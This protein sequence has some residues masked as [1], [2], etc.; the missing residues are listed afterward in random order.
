VRR[1]RGRLLGRL[2]AMSARD[3]LVVG[4]PVVLVIAVAGWLAFKLVRPAPPNII[5][6]I[7][8][9]EGSS[10]RSNA[11]KYKKIIEKHGVKVEILT[12]KGSLD[13]LKLLAD[14]KYHGDVA[15]VQG[16][17]IEGVDVTGLMSLGT[18][19]AQP[20]MVYHREPQPVEVLSQLQ[21]K[22]LAIG[23]E[24]S[25]T[26]VLA[27]KLLKAN[28]IEGPPTVFVD[29]GGEEAA[30]AL[31]TGA[32]D[33]AFL[34]GDSATPK[35]MRGL[36][37]TPGVEM[38][39]FRQ[40]EGYLRKFRF[41]TRL[42]LPEGA[43]DLGKNFP[44]RTI[45]LLG[46][47][48]ELVARDDLHPALSDL[49][50]SAAREV[51][52]GPGMYRN[53]GE[54]PNP[55]EREFPISPD[56]E[57]YYKSGAQFLYKRLPF[58]MASLVDRLMVLIV[59]LLVLLVPATRAAPGLYRWRVR[60]R[61][62]RWYGAL[63]AIEREMMAGP[64]PEQHRE[65]TRRLDDIEHSVNEIKTPLSFADQLYVLREH[66]GQVRRR[67]QNGGAQPAA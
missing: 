12:S 36:R 10:Y 61:I 54:Y 51:H 46:P 29:L 16:G 53:A 47:T 33:A 45:Q 27:L 18:V 5:K 19:L 37:E 42:T 13:N 31:T 9:L 44:P 25:G 21:G 41:L 66:V 11:E 49:L 4:A 23:P 26:R 20:L 35:V 22:R 3:L 59:P 40:V 43:M 63:M 24:G 48:V 6:F 58:W 39:S 55:V 64:T 57:R 65:L 14:P 56:A 67:L 2:A 38:V 32:V 1:V 28:G 8:G 30:K 62:Y 15:F 34:M 52:G 60:S 7:G 17:M 50:I